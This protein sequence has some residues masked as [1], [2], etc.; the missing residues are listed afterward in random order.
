MGVQQGTDRCQGMLETRE[1]L[2]G[3][4]PLHPEL[5][6]S[7]WHLTSLGKAVREG[8][9]W[10]ASRQGRG[11]G[12]GTTLGAHPRCPQRVRTQQPSLPAATWHS[13]VR[14]ESFWEQPGG[15]PWETALWGCSGPGPS[16][17]PPFPQ[18]AP[19]LGPQGLV[20]ESAMCVNVCKAWRFPPPAPRHLRACGL[21][22]V[23]QGRP[24]P[25]GAYSPGL[26]EQAP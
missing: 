22:P 14:Q 10:L 1:Y 16:P 9:S 5:V 20:N 12:L 2:V 17:G 3:K 18:A 24:P 15:H 19:L 21:L 13:R 7:S 4:G 11:G 6:G 8:T 26:S 25:L 23:P